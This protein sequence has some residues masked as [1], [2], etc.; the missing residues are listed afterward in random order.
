M[1]DQIKILVVDDEENIRFAVSNIL[2][3]NGYRA[4]TAANGEEAFLELKKQP[5]DF[6]ICDIKMPRMDGR[7]LLRALQHNRIDTTVIMMSAYGTIDSALESIKAG[8]YDYI[9]KPFKP[10]ELILT[11]KKA[12]ERLKLYRE[13]LTLKKAVAKE[14]DFSAIIGKSEKILNVLNEIKKVAGLKTTVLITGE[15]GTGKELVAKAIHYNS[16]RKNKPFISINCGAIPEN[17]L[18]SELFGYAKGAFTGAYASKQGLFEA[19]DGG[20]LFLDEIGEMPFTL[21]VKLL[22]AI[23]QSQI[24]RIGDTRSITIDVRFLAATSKELSDEVKNGKFRS[25]LY[26][27]LN[28]F[29]IKLPPLRE[30][31]EDIPLLA[32]AFLKKN[33]VNLSKSI[34]GFDE[35]VIELFMKNAWY[36]NVRELENV[37]ERACILTEKELIMPEVIPD[38]IQSQER[39]VPSG[40]EGGFSIKQAQKKYEVDLINKALKETGGNKTRAAQ[41]LEI[42]LRA[43]MYKLKEY[44]IE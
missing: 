39:M 42:S 11:V 26:Y 13:N 34:K 33:A 14:F 9:T 40:T 3:T 31:R 20:T 30:R 24:F 7:E 2:T 16:E 43:L 28:V 36:G 44:G 18:E 10:D 1:A 23:E 21:Q 22:R 25:D 29:N 37:I 17:L 4:D 32:D 15:S 5:Y 38:T 12:E 41:L 6:V 27:R 19:A 35:S 8:A